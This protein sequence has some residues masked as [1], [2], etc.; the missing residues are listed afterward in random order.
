MTTTEETKTYTPILWAN[1]V[2]PVYTTNGIKDE[3]VEEMIED[4]HNSGYQIFYLIAN[5]ATKQQIETKMTSSYTKRET[6]VT[7]SPKILKCT[8]NIAGRSVSAVTTGSL[9]FGAV[10][11]QAFYNLPKMS[12]EFVER[13]DDFFRFVHNQH[14]TEA[15]VI[16]TYDSTYLES[17]NP[18]DGWG[19][20][21]PKQENTAA[22]CDYD[23]QSILDIL[24]DEYDHIYQV[25]TA[26]SHPMM[27]AYCSGTDKADQA[28]FDGVHITFGWKGPVTEH[29]IELQMGETAWTLRTDQVFD[30]EVTEVDDNVK[31][32][33]NQVTKKTITSYGGYT[34]TG[35]TA[36]KHVSQ[37]DVTK[38]VKEF[39][40]DEVPGPDVATIIYAPIMHR[41]SLTE[42]PVCKNE[43][44]NV[45]NAR[46]YKC[47]TYIL[48]PSESMEDLIAL[49]RKHLPS[50]SVDIDP[51]TKPHKSIWLVEED[52]DEKAQEIFRYQQLHDAP[53]TK[54]VRGVKTAPRK[55][56]TDSYDIFE[57]KYTDDDSPVFD[58][59]V[60][61]E[62]GGKN[63]MHAW[64][65]EEDGCDSFTFVPPG[66]SITPKK[67]EEQERDF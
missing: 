32:W 33:A 46:C 20:A 43:H 38:M 63:E 54:L 60:C 59:I 48:D 47:L 50:A 10:K 13:L 6:I 52:Y 36:H 64:Q 66:T 25:G 57:R 65:C 61:T 39:L 17:D 28:S 27:E 2:F 29:F 49:R 15:I 62:C 53:N 19:I 58:Y 42:C 21:V 35:T 16:F 14:G 5:E 22:S 44:I 55:G 24:P 26:H 1:D 3:D 12:A 11:P 8:K 30:F 31:S 23:Q 40:P 67:K 34:G 37:Q 9:P 51:S 18:A 4:I 41:I 7:K 45:A 56:G